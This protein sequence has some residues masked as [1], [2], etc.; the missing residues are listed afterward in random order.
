MNPIHKTLS[1]WQFMLLTLQVVCL[2]NIFYCTL[3]LPV[4]KLLGRAPILCIAARYSACCIQVGQEL[5]DVL[6]ER[7][8]LKVV[9]QELALRLTFQAAPEAALDGS[10]AAEVGVNSNY[11]I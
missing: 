9:N 7:D 10:G 5:E 1:P 4:C 2:L 3:S 11:G 8:A 6:A